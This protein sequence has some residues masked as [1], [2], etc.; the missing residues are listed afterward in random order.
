METRYDRNIPAL[1]EQ[2]CALL[3]TKKVAVIGCGGLGGYLIE[4]LSRIG[5]GAIRAVDGD[6]F[7]ETN[8]NRQLLSDCAA[9]GNSKAEAAAARVRL[10]NPEIT[11]EAIPVFLK[12]E[13]AAELIS[14]CEAV[15]DAL[16]SIPARKTLARACAAAG[17]PY[18]YGSISG[19]IAQAGISMPGD[20][21]MD[22]L[23]PDSTRI[24]DKSVLSFTP[25]LCASM[26]AA[27]CV[28]WLTG[29]S[30]DT[31]T[32]YYF[33]LLNQEFETIPLA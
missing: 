16:D 23:Y 29:R 17:I 25:A 22:I 31:G 4:Y 5:I 1:T 2:E 33:D 21:M 6:V 3:R 19:W 8:L 12:E 28:K 7:D 32:L 27:L 24:R 18:V 10:V 15:L 11:V 9:I 26:Q 20:G 30:V 13:N 14:G